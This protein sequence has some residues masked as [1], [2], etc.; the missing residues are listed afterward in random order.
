MLLF[1]VNLPDEVI[2]DGEVVLVPFVSDFFD[3]DFEDEKDLEEFAEVLDF[4][5]LENILFADESVK[6]LLPTK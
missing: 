1:R 6:H 4:I 2:L 3:D 5:G